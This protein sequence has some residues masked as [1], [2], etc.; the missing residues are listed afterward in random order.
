MHVRALSCFLQSKEIVTLI[1][2]GT[3]AL[4]NEKNENE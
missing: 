2:Y 1:V 3:R 4:A